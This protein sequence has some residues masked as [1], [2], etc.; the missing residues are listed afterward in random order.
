MSEADVVTVRVIEPETM[1]GTDATLWD[2]ETNPV[3]RTTIVAV[4]ILD[5]EVAEDR[6][7]EALD[8]GSRLVPRLRQRVVEAPLGAGPPRWVLDESVQVTDHFR[9]VDLDPPLTP[10]DLFSIAGDCATEPFD[11]TRPLWEAVYVGGLERGRSALILK[12]HHSL[13][14]GVGGVGLLDAVLD[15]SRHPTERPP[16]S[17]P[18]L[19]APDRTVGLQVPSMGSVVARSVGV[20]RSAARMAVDLVRSPGRAASSIVE[21]GRSAYRLLAPSGAPLSPLFTERGPDRSLGIH[22]LDLSRL[23]A[24]A[25]RHDCTINQLFFAGVVGGVTAYHRTHGSP[26]DEL[27]LLM[28][29]SVR[30]SRDGAAGNQWAPVRFRVPATIDDPVARMMAMRRITRRSRKEKALGFSHALSGAIQMFPSALSSGIVSGMTRGIDGTLTNVP[31]LSEPRYLA[32]AHVERMYAFAPT[33]GQAFNVSLL[34]HE[35]T[36]CVGMM[37]DSAAVDEPTR[38][39][40]LIADHLD[41]TLEAVES[42]PANPAIEPLLERDHRPERLTSLD[43]VF[44]RI[45]EPSYPMHIGGVLVLDGGPLRDDDGGLRIDD[46]RD[47]IESRLGRMPRYLRRLREVPLGQGRPLWVDDAEFDIVHHV[48]VTAIGSPGGRDELLARCCELNM[49]VL[50]RSRPL[51]ELWFVDGP[52]DGSVGLLLKIHHALLDGISSVEFV[53]TLFDLEPTSEAE[54]PVRLPTPQPPSDMDLVADAW[55]ER[56]RDPAAL[57]RSSGD[58]LRR[59]PGEALNGVTEAVGAVAGVLGPS[60]RAPRSPLN[61]RVGHRRRLASTEMSSAEIAE[62]RDRLG[63]SPN[64][65][66]LAVLTGGLHRWFEDHHEPLEDLHAM[67]PVSTRPRSD[68]GAGGNVVGAMTIPLPLS[69]PDPT[70][71]LAIISERTTRAKHEHQ[72]A[73]VA[74]T[75]GAVDHIP[76]MVP[77][78]VGAAVRSFIANQSYVNLVV[79]NVPGSPLPLYLLGAEATSITPV[80]P[81]GPNT[82]LGVALLSYTDSLTFGLH[83][84][85]DLCPDLDRL[86]E[87]IRQAADDLLAAARSHR[88]TSDRGRRD[89][90]G[91]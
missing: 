32:G 41:E 67:V 12:L 38:L 3:L 15:A 82:A 81:L 34:S 20:Q 30:D 68:A 80:V 74:T 71:R 84:D 64:D 40:T 27:R 72:G 5:T 88:G 75:L 31:G 70:R 21:G 37:V 4:M 28:P 39:H 85:P 14:D 59:A 17:V 13:T 57:L 77:G 50:D 83:V 23:H 44:L 65:V 55:T 89:E 2:I 69:E 47:H 22:E 48:K 25:A 7:L 54:R 73:G 8:V 45:E 62:I 29:I 91:R 33:T 16:G 53:S 43:S 58:R 51:W 24:A 6:L 86:V 26:L 11:R 36:A 66:A 90:P 1:N 19:R 56:L 42:A 52:A 61:R 9:T 78:V 35:Q 63:G 49:E 87:E 10:D 18:Q 79:T 46:L 60:G 76:P